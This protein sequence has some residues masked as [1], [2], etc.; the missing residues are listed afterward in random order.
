MTGVA[1]LGWSAIFRRMDGFGISYP[2]V[3]GM[4]KKVNQI[5]CCG[6][7]S[8]EEEQFMVSFGDF[9]SFNPGGEGGISKCRSDRGRGDDDAVF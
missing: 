4:K 1:L 5:L 7:R 8:Q 6:R 9:S 3:G 2:G